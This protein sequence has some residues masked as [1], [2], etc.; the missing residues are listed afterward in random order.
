MRLIGACVGTFV[1]GRGGAD[2]HPLL[3]LATAHQEAGDGLAGQEGVRLR[4]LLGREE[5]GCHGCCC[6]SQCVCVDCTGMTPG[7]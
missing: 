3:T 5:G 1:V 2:V 7:L 4:D 6:M